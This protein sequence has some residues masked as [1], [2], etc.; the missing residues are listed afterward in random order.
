MATN[1]TGQSAYNAF[2]AL[3]D[4]MKRLRENAQKKSGITEPANDTSYAMPGQ[5][6]D[7]ANTMLKGPKPVEYKPMQNM[8]SMPEYQA[9]TQ[10]TVM[11]PQYY[12]N[13][14]N[15]ASNEITEAY[16]KQG[17]FYDR[18]MGNLNE[19][20]LATSG[21]AN[22]QT[23]RMG[24]D[25]AK[26]LA[27]ARA[28]LESEAMGHQFSAD[29]SFANRM[30]SLM[31]LR[32]GREQFDT[33]MGTNVDQINQ[34]M[35][36]AVQ[37]GQIGLA[38][39]LAEA[40]NSI[41]NQEYQNQYQSELAQLQSDMARWQ[42]ADQ[43]GGQADIGGDQEAALAKIHGYPYEQY[44]PP[45]TGSAIGQTWGDQKLP[46]F[47]PVPQSM[48]QINSQTGGWTA[49]DFTGVMNGW[50]YQNGKPIKPWG[51]GF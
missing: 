14:W 1:S 39:Q 45:T 47:Y 25:L 41:I 51:P 19:R 31:G 30:G 33:S 37:T 29:E 26:E 40:K 20:N 27:T 8:S 38:Q 7:Q 6:V 43:L 46:N 11:D 28:G 36:W 18:M 44:T 24:S 10:K 21:E 34:Q 13:K 50:Y 9:A 42:M 3:S 49:S 17:G 12:A 48:D 35:D 23:R 16:G 22:A 4:M 5:Y 32:S 2:G 15:T